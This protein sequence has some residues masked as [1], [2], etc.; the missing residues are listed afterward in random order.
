MSALHGL[1]G[2]RLCLEL[3]VICA[4]LMREKLYNEYAGSDVEPVDQYALS[5]H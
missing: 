4:T 2:G 3:V 1:Q 5:G